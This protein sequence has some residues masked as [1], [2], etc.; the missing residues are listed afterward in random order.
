[1]A[2]NIESA[3]VPVSASLPV[4]HTR[5]ADPAK[6]AAQAPPQEATAP[7]VQTPNYDYRLRVD[8][9]THEV[10]LVV[11]DL[12]TREPIREIPAQEMHT[13]SNVIRDL[14][15]PVVDKIA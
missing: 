4:R 13:A 15:G 10:V 8:K 6:S 2:N 3:A 5:P 11:L 9:Q 7:V 1:M 12:R 14:I